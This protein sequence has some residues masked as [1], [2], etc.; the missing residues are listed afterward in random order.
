MQQ[1]LKLRTALY[2]PNFSIRSWR[3]LR[4]F[5]FC[6]GNARTR[7]IVYK[8]RRYRIFCIL[9]YHINTLELKTK[10]TFLTNT[11]YCWI[12]HTVSFPKQCEKVTLS[13]WANIFYRLTL[14]LEVLKEDPKLQGFFLTHI[15]LYYIWTK[16]DHNKGFEKITITSQFTKRKKD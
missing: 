12:T 11:E 3:N 2:T 6:E 1:L 4:S 9:L 5:I 14:T 16:N 15:V 13:N 7:I 8:R 10:I